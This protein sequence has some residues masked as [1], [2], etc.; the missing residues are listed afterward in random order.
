MIRAFD[1]GA[2]DYLV[3]PFPMNVLLKHIEAVL[4]RTEEEKNIFHYMDLTV[5]FDS[6]RVTYREQEIKLTVKEF[7]LLTILIKNK[8]QVVTKEL[9]LDKVW[10]QSGAF[11]EEHTINVTL[12]RLRKKIEPDPTNPKFIKNVFGLG[13]VFRK[14]GKR[15]FEEKEKMEALSLVLEKLI[16]DEPIDSMQGD[17]DTLPSKIRH[18]MIRLSDKMRG[19]EEQLIK[20]RDE[21]KGLISEIAHQLRNPLAN[22]EGYLQLLEEGAGSRERESAYIDAIAVSERRIRFLTESFIKMARLESKV[23]QI[24]KESADL[25]KTLLRSILQVQGAA[26]EKK[27]EYPAADG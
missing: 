27:I 1:L 12:S 3:K 19:N 25:K 16:N 7:Q 15:C 5:D 18:Q 14:V 20:D 6:R 2:D 13:Y 9:I 11:V 17:K 24:K 23:I 22:M 8:G 4:R 26:V 10:D 21:I